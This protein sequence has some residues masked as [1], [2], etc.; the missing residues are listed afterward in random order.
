MAQTTEI[1]L[2][3]PEFKKNPYPLFE[4]LRTNQP[5]A[6]VNLAGNRPA[7]LISRYQE[8]E[9]VLKDQ[10]FVKDAANAFTLEEL[11]S[12]FP[13]RAASNDDEDRPR[14][15]LFHRQMLNT[16]PP[17]HTRLRSLVNM[18]FTPRM[19]EQWRGRIQTI[20]DELLDAVQEKGEMELIG[21]FAF[22]LPITVITEMLGIPVADRMQFRAWS[23][24]VIE[25]SGNPEAFVHMREHLH[26]FGEYLVKLINEKRAQTGDDLLSKLIRA[27]SEGDKLSEEELVSMV[28]LL[29]V[30]GHETTVN[31]IGNGILA[32]LQHPDQMELLKK[33][34][35]LITSAVEEFLRYQG[36]LLTATQRWA[37]EDVELAGQHI[38]RGDYV[39]VLLA[40]ANRDGEEFAQAD[41][42]DITRKDNHHLAFGKGIHFCL[43]A[44]L[45]RLE[46]QIAIGTLLRR[47]PD[48][49]LAIDLDQLQWRPGA[50]IMGLS[51]LP[52]AF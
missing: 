49:R 48:L 36:P 24:G 28:F 17:D 39:V 30:A 51:K 12:F 22:P 47:M 13:L 2:F 44:P 31:L 7:W 26:A 19:V 10:R 40:S 23:N 14:P 5:V 11:A 6:Q 41:K 42:L 29:L 1:A 8:A 33:D 50:L 52:V 18:A 15:F 34:P 21:D 35:S 25:S 46:G 37:R 43:G 3:L 32:L 9:L 38:K 27:E 20:T 16:D 4:M 45:A